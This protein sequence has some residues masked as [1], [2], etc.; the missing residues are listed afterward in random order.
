MLILMILKG[1]FFFFFFLIVADKLV[2]CQ[3]VCLKGGPNKGRVV[4]LIGGG[5]VTVCAR[6]EREF[7]S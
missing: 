4:S 2:G 6:E 5:A 7:V 3:L 1:V